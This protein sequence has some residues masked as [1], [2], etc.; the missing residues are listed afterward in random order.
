MLL[1]RHA[2]ADRTL[3]LALIG[4]ALGTYQELGMTTWAKRASELKLALR[5]VPAAGH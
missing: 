5:V 2:D 1:A 3:G 4:Q